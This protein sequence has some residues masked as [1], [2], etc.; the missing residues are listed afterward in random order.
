MYEYSNKPEP[1]YCSFCGINIRKLKCVIKARKGCSTCICDACVVICA[2][3]VEAH[4]AGR[5]PITKES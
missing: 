3:I 4:E 5:E 1:I 2:A